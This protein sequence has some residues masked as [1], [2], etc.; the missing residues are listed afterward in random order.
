MSAP[1][2][3]SVTKMLRKRDEAEIEKLMREKYPHLNEKQARRAAR[4]LL[5]LRKFHE[6]IARAGHVE[7]P[8]TIA[9][10]VRD[11]MQSWIN[12]SEGLK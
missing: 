2:N 5:A 9:A 8:R 6:R 1:K 10:P 11:I 4:E 3:Y 12:R 7:L